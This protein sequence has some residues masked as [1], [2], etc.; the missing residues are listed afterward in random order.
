[1]L[2]ERG[3]Q[4]ST[5]D[6]VAC[7]GEGVVI[8]AFIGDVTDEAALVSAIEGIDTVF[9]VASIIDITPMPALSKCIT[10]MSLAL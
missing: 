7:S 1:M 8:Q 5:C 10:P 4:A 2:L 6:L 9:H 3:H